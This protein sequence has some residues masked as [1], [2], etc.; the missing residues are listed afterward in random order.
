MNGEIVVIF[1]GERHR[2]PNPNGDMIIGNGT[3]PDGSAVTIKGTSPP[4][5]LQR[6]RCY[7]LFGRWQDYRNPRSGVSDEQ[8]HFTSLVESEPA[9]ETGVVSYLKEYGKG[10]GLGVSTARA[11]W[12]KFGE[13][14][15]RWFRESSAN[16]IREQFPKL[17]PKNIGEIQKVLHIRR[18]TER[19]TVDLMNLLSGQG[20]PRS[21]VR[22]AIET[23]GVEAADLIRRNPFWLMRFRGVGFRRCDRMYMSL[24]LPPGRLKRQALCAWYGVE[25]QHNET[26]STWI[27]AKVARSMV[28]AMVSGAELREDDAVR[29]AVRAEILRSMWTD[30]GEID[31]DGTDQWL[32]DRRKATAEAK[33]AS[34]IAD[35]LMD[36]FQFEP[37]EYESL[38]PHQNKKLRELFS[39]KNCLKILRGSGGTGKTR[40]AAAIAS[41]LL[42]RFG[43]NKV[44]LAAPTGKAAVRLTEAMNEL[45]VK[46][47]ASTWHSLLKVQTASD[48]GWSFEHHEKNPLP[49]KV[50]IAD[51]CSMQDTTM[52]ERAFAARGKGTL[53]LFLGDTGQ[54]AP[55]GHGAPLRD[56]LASPHVPEAE[57]T[58]THRNGGRLVEEANRL[59]TE[60]IID[61]PV[62]EDLEEF[63]SN[64]ELIPCHSKDLT[65]KIL[66]AVDLA[67]SMRK[68]PENPFSYIDPVWDCQVIVATNRYRKDLNKILQRQ[69]NP[70]DSQGD[71]PFRIDDKVVVTANTWMPSKEF[72]MNNTR[73]RERDGKHEVYVANGDVGKVIA[74]EGRAVTVE[75][76]SPHRIVTFFRGKAE[77]D[78]R[79]KDGD[80]NATESDG[81][82][83]T[84]CN[85]EL[86]YAISAHK[87]Q[88]SEYP[89][90]IV[91]LDDSGGAMRVCSREWLY[92]AITRAKKYCICVGAQETADRMARIE[93][94]ADRKTFLTQL[95]SKEWYDAKDV[96]LLSVRKSLAERKVESDQFLTRAKEMFS[97]QKNGLTVDSRS[98]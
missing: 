1:D 72:D 57:L 55:V 12:E 70:G 90:A 78:D 77:K 41:H 24:G 21:I 66:S 42:Q 61:L 35:A 80:S 13:D 69:L 3:L 87:S 15:I 20:M 29:L 94:T 85:L 37:Q 95:I 75:L 71:S 97:C 81:P 11:M 83:E 34:R 86:A 30:G 16:E 62:R 53:F 76:Y 51:E 4:Q 73:S 64:I 56:M 84:G 52:M 47:Q 43:A 54:L 48:G 22:D 39:Q 23:W 31:W 10:R 28:R 2:W 17:T 19:A 74:Q 26:G 33:L 65:R 58:K 63:K 93:K 18:R 25:L 38:S 89:V 27:T 8:F 68:E 9:T 96:K 44:A 14:A 67:S 98:S 60:G 6:G 82:S 5:D 49:H 59:R 36:P 32:S 50:V 40:T 91:A 88:G 46:L 79:P 45:G 7:R 92:T